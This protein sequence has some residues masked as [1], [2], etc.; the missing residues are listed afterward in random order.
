MTE[1]TT[2]GRRDGVK[3]ALVNNRLQ[4]IARKMSNTLARTGRSGVLNIARDFSCCIVSADDELVA[5]AESLPIHVLSGPD[6]MSK[7]MKEL[8]PGFL[9]GMCSST[10]RRTTGVRILRTTRCLRRCSMQKANTGSPSS[11]RHT[12]RIA[13][14]PSRR[15]TWGPHATCMKRAR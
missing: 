3:L 11:S 7:S 1:N 5:A 13:A 8:H 6:L 10:T 15:P 9:P 12:R 4:G 14:I 2:Q